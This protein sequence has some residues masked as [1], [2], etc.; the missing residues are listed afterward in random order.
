MAERVLQPKEEEL[1]KRE[2]QLAYELKACLDGFKRA[3][4]YAKNLQEAIIS[5]NELFLLVVVGEFNA[6]KSALINALLHDKVLE[7]GVTETTKQITIVRYGEK[8]KQFQPD[9]KTVELLHPADFLQE[10]IIADTP[11]TNTP[12][13]EHVRLTTDFIPRGDLI[14]FVMRAD[15]P[16]T[17]SERK[18]LG[19]IRKW[20]KKV[21]IVLNRIDTLSTP[22]ALAKVITSVQTKCK[23]LLG[24][25]PDIFPVS[26]LQAQES[27]I[28]LGPKARQLWQNSRFGVLEEYLFQRLGQ[29]ERKRDKLLNPLDTMQSVSTNTQ[30]LVENHAR[31]IDQDEVI[32]DT[33][34]DKLN[35]Y[36]KDME[37]DFPNRLSK[38]ENILLEMRASGDSFFDDTIRLRNFL[39]LLEAGQVSD[40]FKYSVIGDREKQI[41]ESVENLINWFVDQED[42]LRRDIVKQLERRRLLITQGDDAMSVNQ[43]VGDNRSDLL[44][45]MAE[46]AKNVMRTYNPQAEA[47]TLSQNLRLAVAGAVGTSGIGL[48]AATVT[49]AVTTLTAGGLIGGAVLVGLGLYIIPAHRTRVKHHFHKQMDELRTK[50]HAVLHEQF[51]RELDNTINHMRNHIKPYEDF[52]T[53]E[54]KKI[55]DTRKQLTDLNAKMAS[56]RLDIQRTF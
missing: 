3:Q 53:L 30:E 18:F 15:Q 19:L 10:I 13:H 31:L 50:L 7:E 56:L 41:D 55:A 9:P 23:N 35:S 4:V 46:S 1:L 12:W 17:E 6:G 39:K 27:D 21:K 44:Q 22:E 37:R 28:T 16:F 51:Y 36:R 52:V 32:I 54:G 29:M 11:G 25:Q 45:T 8:G 40:E 33:I 2:R 14:L 49:F 5:L 48:G 42:D 26:V 38:I 34:Y 20:G 43:Q 24:S 47:Q